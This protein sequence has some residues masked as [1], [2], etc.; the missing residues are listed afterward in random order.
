MKAELGVH[1]NNIYVIILKLH[2][3]RSRL[4]HLQYTVITNFYYKF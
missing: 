1:A 2:T 3:F 4:G